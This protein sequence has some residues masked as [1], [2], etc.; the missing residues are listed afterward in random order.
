M[1]PQVK[2]IGQVPLASVLLPFG[3]RLELTPY[4]ILNMFVT[5][6][7]II[8]I[9]NAFNLLDNMDGLAAGIAGIPI[10]FR[11][12]FF[13]WSGDLVNAVAAGIFG[14]AVLGFLV[15]NSPPWTI[16]MGD[17]GSLFV[18]FFLAASRFPAGWRTPGA[19]SAS[20][21]C[22]CFSSSYRSSTRPS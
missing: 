7:W 4:S 3:F 6:F 17:T 14:G 19:S 10:A 5:I 18:G 1:K 22:R 11:A 2:L 20:S 13:V 9:T 15:R 12:L 21:H 16:F 8:G